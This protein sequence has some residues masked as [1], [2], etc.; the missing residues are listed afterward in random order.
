MGAAT[1]RASPT[2][3]AAGRRPRAEAADTLA[4]RIERVAT[5]LFIRDG[6]HGVSYLDIARELGITHSN[7]HY[8]YR[9]KADLAGAVL[10]RVARD[11]LAATGAI[12][13]DA[14]AP[15]PEK[16]V[17]MRDWIY[18]SYLQFNPDGKGGR[19]W[20][21]LSRFSMEADALSP[22]MRQL[23]RAT[24]KRLEA[25]LQ[26]AVAAAVERGELVA[27]TP[28]DGVVLQIANVMYQTGHLTRYAAGFARLDELLRWTITI[29]GRAYG[30]GWQARIDWPE[31]RDATARAA[32]TAT[33]GKT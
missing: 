5:A 13:R 27:D 2:R 10:K 14:A 33:G 16:F 31:P 28:V 19:P 1:T 22:E 12:W 9:N 17:R 21:L 3:A 18:R 32:S 8:Y 29:L 15:L 26:S 6:Y 25:D 20:G 23:I 4:E 7:V 30:T 11:T 24:L